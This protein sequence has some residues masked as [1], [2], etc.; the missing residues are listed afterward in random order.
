[1]TVSKSAAEV[2]IVDCAPRDGLS[3]IQKVVPTPDKIRFIDSLVKAGLTKIDC[4][5]FTHPRLIPENADAE[6][7]VEGL[8][9]RPGVTYIG[10]VPSEVGCRRAILTQIDEILTLVAASEAFNRAALGLSRRK[11]LN[12][13]LPAIFDIARDAGKT[14]RV[15]ILTSFGCPYGG[16]VSPDEVL[17]I[18]SRLA[19]M[20]ANEITLLDSTGMANPRQ[21]KETIKLVL[22]SNLD[23]DFAVHMHDTRGTGLVNCI[24]AY[25]AGI[26]I[27]DTAVAGLSG[28]PFGAPEKDIGFWNIPTE[29]LVHLF[30]QM[31]VRTGVDMAYLLEAVKLAEKIAGR[32]LP[33]HILRAG[34][35]TELAE[36]PEP[37]HLK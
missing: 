3:A 30:H 14:I 22:G 13:T 33:G 20:G 4:V 1:M 24:A 17:N 31:G 32:P 9:K 6:K 12:K 10:L 15:Y 37:L 34:M 8:K 16:Y 23:A 25:E 5:A 2:T 21:V 27:F 36:I 18:A 11:L 35:N 28:T 29:D 26:R 7:V 19:F